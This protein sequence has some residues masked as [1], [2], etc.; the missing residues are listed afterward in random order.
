VIEAT[1]LGVGR[2]AREQQLGVG[3]QPAKD[4]FDPLIL[5][6]SRGQRRAGGASKLA[7]ERYGEVLCR[8]LSLGKICLDSGTVRRRVEITEIPGR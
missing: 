2:I 5:A 1:D 3:Y 4:L 8:L 6:D 7:L